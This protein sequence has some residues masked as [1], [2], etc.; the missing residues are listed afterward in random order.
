MLSLPVR[1]QVAVIGFIDPTPGVK[2]GQTMIPKGQLVSIR[3]MHTQLHPAIATF[4]I[5]SLVFLGVHEPW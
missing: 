1:C 4:T 3:P 5:Y 2:S